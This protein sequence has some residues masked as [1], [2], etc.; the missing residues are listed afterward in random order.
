MSHVSVLGQEITALRARGTSFNLI[1]SSKAAFLV[2]L[3]KTKH[4]LL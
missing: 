3:V 4:G 2:A 1:P